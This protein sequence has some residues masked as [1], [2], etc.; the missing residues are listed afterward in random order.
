MMEQ[1]E[2]PDHPMFVGRAAYPAT[3][4]MGKSPRGIAYK[5][6]PALLMPSAIHF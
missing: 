1:R 5:F 4:P 2:P 6:S 3:A